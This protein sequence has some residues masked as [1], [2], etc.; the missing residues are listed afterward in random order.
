MAIV[1]KLIS[2]IDASPV[3]TTI[4][5][6]LKTG[7]NVRITKL[8]KPNTIEI[9]RQRPQNDCIKTI[10]QKIKGIYQ[11]KKVIEEYRFGII[12]IDYKKDG[13]RLVKIKT[14]DKNGRGAS[15]NNGFYKMTAEENLYP[16]GSIIRSFEQEQQIPYKDRNASLSFLSHLNTIR[17]KHRYKIPTKNYTVEQDFRY[18]DVDLKNCKKNR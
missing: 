17:K 15:S 2:R 9:V 3:G 12:S 10:L 14:S 1:S 18:A 8:S 5:T 7:T 11:P 4:N 16:K 6:T 13:S